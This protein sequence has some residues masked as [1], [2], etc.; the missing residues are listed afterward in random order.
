MKAIK[1]TK[2]IGISM[3]LVGGASGEDSASPDCPWSYLLPSLVLR[4]Q[5]Q[6]PSTDMNTEATTYEVIALGCFFHKRLRI[7]FSSR[8]GVRSLTATSAYG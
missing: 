8:S 3:L 6:T 4:M 5:S 1:P 7:S 2:S